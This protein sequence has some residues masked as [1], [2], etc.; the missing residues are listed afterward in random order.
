MQLIT[1]RGMQ[2]LAANHEPTAQEKQEDSIVAM[3]KDSALS[4]DEVARSLVTLVVSRAY[5]LA[6]GRSRVNSSTSNVSE[7]SMQELAF[8]LHSCT[9]KS[10]LLQFLGINPTGA[11]L[12]LKVNYA[13]PRLPRFFHPSVEAPKTIGAS[14]QLTSNFSTVIDIKQVRGTRNWMFSYDD[15]VYFPAYSMIHYPE[16]W[17]VIGVSGLRRIWGPYKAT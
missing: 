14:S 4:S 12:R 7:S 11:S 5:N 10:A 2:L 13:D 16:G 17:F 1:A 3:I 9:S 6:R 8:A 15:T